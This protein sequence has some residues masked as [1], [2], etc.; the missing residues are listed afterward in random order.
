MTDDS[1]AFR[2]SSGSRPDDR[3]ASSDPVN[4]ASAGRHTRRRASQAGRSWVQGRVT[5]ALDHREQRRPIWIDCG[6]R[7]SVSA[8]GSCIRR[9]GQFQVGDAGETGAIDEGN[10]PASHRHVSG[11]H[12][13]SA[14]PKA[15]PARQVASLWPGLSQRVWDCLLGSFCLG[16]KWAYRRQSP[17]AHNPR[18]NSE[19]GVV[20]HARSH[21]FS[22]DFGRISWHTD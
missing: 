5:G 13:P 6:R 18:P 14:G 17:L 15:R 16:S 7:S 4:P 8:G 19:H 20:V 22:M 12:R 1:Q 10:Q 2:I 11:S 3:A 9:P 21:V